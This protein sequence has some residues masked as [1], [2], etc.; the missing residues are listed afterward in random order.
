MQ[1]RTFNKITGMIRKNKKMFWIGVLTVGLMLVFLFRGLG[2]GMVVEVGFVIRSDINNVVEQTGDVEAAKKQNIYALYGGRIKAIPVEVGQTV[3]EGQLLLEFDRD[4]LDIRLSQAEAG[5]AL[6]EGSAVT[7]VDSAAALAAYEGAAVKRD[8]AKGTFNNAMELFEIGALSEVELNEARE[9]FDLAE[10]QLRAAMATLE[11]ANKVTESQGASL[12]AARAEVLLVKRQIE[13]IK[14]VSSIEGVV[15]EIGFEEGMVVPPGSLIMQVGDPGDLQVRCKFLAG[16]TVDIK[17]GNDALIKGD[18]LEGVILQGRV[19]RVYPRAITEV[20]RLGVEQQRV[21]VEIELN[22]GHKNLRPGFVV[23]VEIITHGAKDALTVPG[24]AVFK[25]DEGYFVFV[26]RDKRAVLNRV[27][28]GIKNDE[29]IQILDGLKE[30]D[31]VVVDPPK[32]I[33]DGTKVKIK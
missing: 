24:D 12:E 6:I 29:R 18:I 16:E 20:S 5:L 17:E 9:G 23:D 2:G 19:K 30:G 1:T 8:R 10:L 32:G 13:E 28:T 3:K 27:K 14:P 33:K 22:K 4:E 25:M 31:A 26:I 11:A 21:P 15:L 7:H